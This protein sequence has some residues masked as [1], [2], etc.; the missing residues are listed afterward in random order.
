MTVLIRRSGTLIAI[1]PSD[2]FG[3]LDPRIVE[4]LHPA[5]K[6]DHVT[7]LRGNERYMPDGQVR[8]V[9]IE[10]QH[11]YRIENNCV[12]T[13]FG[14]LER[15]KEIFRINGV[16]VKYLDQSP[17]K[18]E[19]VYVPDW[20]NLRQYVTFRPRQEEC[21]QAI[22]NNECGLINA[23]MGFGKTHLFE[24][25]A[26]LY[27]KAKI[28][29]VV[30][31]KDVAKR[32]VRRMSRNI[33]NVGQIGG[34]RKFRGDRVTV[35]TAGSA[36]YAYGTEAD[37]LLA[38]EVHTL[39]TDKT[40]QALADNWLYTRNFGATATPD[41]RIDNADAKLE[42]FF[43]KEIFYM[44]YSE[45]V[46]LGLVVPIKV[47]WI[48][49]NLDHNP[50]MGRTGTPRMRWGIWRNDARNRM[51]AQDVRDNYQDPNTQILILV[52]TFDHAA[53]LWQHLPEFAMCYSNADESKIE[54]YKRSRILPDNFVPTTPERRETMRAQFEDGTLKRVI[55]TDVWST[56]VDFAQL[57]VLYRADARSSENLDAQGPGRV[58]RLSPATGKEFGEVID[59][60]DSFDKSLKRK[61]EERKRHYRK[62]GWE[63][64]WPQGRRPISYA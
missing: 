58:S 27:P 12:I 39:M 56:G 10:P 57:Q 32:L 50:A 37:F 28:D 16:T 41:G 33:P 3:E 42:M 18:P 24:Q 51:I 48:N 20:D 38:D 62:L 47:R 5:L 52:A 4:M 64:D 13:G 15:I 14:F 43:G 31:Q 21:L 19:G 45:A 63:Q 8:N 11:M 61:S 54:S 36:H 1:G 25:V 23:T 7:V 30:K 34:G 6:Y 49:I 46:E 60:C 22:T 26:H 2:Y 55:A 40:S 59:C 9:D 17:Q 53:Y 35:Y 44:P 29:I